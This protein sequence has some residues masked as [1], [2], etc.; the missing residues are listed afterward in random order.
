MKK[1]IDMTKIC[2]IYTDENESRIALQLETGHGPSTW[3]LPF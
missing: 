2:C 1:T 3:F